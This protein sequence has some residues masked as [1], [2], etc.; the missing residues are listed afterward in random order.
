MFEIYSRSNVLPFK[1][2]KVP[3]KRHR[4]SNIPSFLSE[5]LFSGF[6]RVEFEFELDGS[7]IG[8]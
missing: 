5:L 7:V 8:R 1:L 4:N 2:I 3:Y 6:Q